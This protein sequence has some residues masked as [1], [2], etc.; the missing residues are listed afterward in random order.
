MERK[1]CFKA[2]VCLLAIIFLTGCASSM[3]SIVSTKARAGY[4]TAI[5]SDLI[6]LPLPERKIVVA[7][8]KFRDQTGQYKHNPQATSFSTAVTQ[9]STSM[10][11]K[12]LE[13][14]KWFIPI[15]REGLPNLLTERKIVRS[16]RE[17]Y[18]N[19]KISPLPPLMY[20]SIIL[21]GGIVAY[22]SNIATGGFGARFFGIG[23]SAESRQDQVT[24]YL[25]ATAVKN[26]RILRT[27]S[28]TKTILSR[29]V[30]FGVYRF[31][32]LKRLLEIETGL[33]TNEP[34]QMC[35]MEAIEKAVFDLIV[36]GILNNDWNLK[37]PENI[38]S[39]VIQ[40][41]LK[42]K[43]GIDEEKMVFDKNGNLKSVKK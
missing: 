39:P 38:N 37:N 14:S 23:G 21:E 40:S 16:T 31:V 25:R 5:H 19:G 24:I 2:I 13:D 36:E 3:R 11:I 35:V 26:G 7:V 22:E 43:E 28:T 4:I 18:K 30:D 8:Y 29:G 33:A 9:G 1:Q 12:A 41:Y 34:P 15:E 20:A 27:V 17:Q 6:S 10:L 42:E 32:R